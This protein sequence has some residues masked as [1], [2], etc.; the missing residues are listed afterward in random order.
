[1][2]TCKYCGESKL[3]WHF[4]KSGRSADKLRTNCRDCCSEI[5]DIRTSTP[6]GMRYCARCKTTKFLEEFASLGHSICQDCYVVEK[7]EYRQTKKGRETERRYTTS[8]TARAARRRYKK[9]DKGVVARRSWRKTE[10]GKQLEF[11]AN[12]KRRLTQPEKIS[13]RAAVSTALKKGVLIKGPCE[14]CGSTK[15]EGHHEDYSKPLE[16]NWLC[17]DH[18]QELHRQCPLAN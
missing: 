14:V 7:R 3:S 10:K 8:D 5:K 4:H 17:Q 2:K 13:A 16:V 11:R 12:R 6:T 9:S 18:H 1:V 15:V